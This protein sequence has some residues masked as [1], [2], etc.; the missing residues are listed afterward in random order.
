MQLALPTMDSPA[1]PAV[2][3]RRPAPVVE[4]PLGE[5]EEEFL[6][7]RGWEPTR[8]VYRQDLA[9]YINWCASEGIDPASSDR[10][11]LE[12]WREWM[13]HDHVDGRTAGSQTRKVGLSGSVIRRRLGVVSSFLDYLI[14]RL[15]R[16]DNP[17]RQVERPLAQDPDGP[18]ARWLSPA[19]TNA[20]LD[21]AQRRGPVHHVLACLMFAYGQPAVH[22]GELRGR[23]IFERD[24]LPHIQ[25]TVRRGRKLTQE[26]VG[27]TRRAIESLGP[28]GDGDPLVWLPGD[29]SSSAL[30]RR[31]TRSIAASARAAG[32]DDVTGIVARHTW[33][34]HARL[35]GVPEAAIVEHSGIEWSAAEQWRR[36]Q[37]AAAIERLLAGLE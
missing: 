4:P 10:A 24:G 22:V 34:A 9:S 18:P 7:S 35:A 15:V 11:A 31:V 37:P 13:L 21:A 23:D 27:R 6:R 3:R 16:T 29:P 8:D 36:A 32:V 26:L 30:R 33:Q 19:Q 5:L 17:T 1:P 14:D 20:I 12:R 28:I 2:R 25:L